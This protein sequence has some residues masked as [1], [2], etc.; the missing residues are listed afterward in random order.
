MKKTFVCKNTKEKSQKK[1][2]LKDSILNSLGVYRNLNKMA[3]TTFK[4]AALI[5]HDG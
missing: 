2:S 4:L 5:Y 3:N 1:Y